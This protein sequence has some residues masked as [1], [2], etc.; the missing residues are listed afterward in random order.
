MG[1][2]S[3]CVD[4]FHHTAK[5]RGRRPAIRRP[6]TAVRSSTSA[7]NAMQATDIP[8]LTDPSFSSIRTQLVKTLR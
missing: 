1:T 7:G 6:T 3:A 8:D 4:A 5:H 2:S